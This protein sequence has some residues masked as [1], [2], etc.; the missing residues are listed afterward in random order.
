MV[1]QVFFSQVRTEVAEFLSKTGMMHWELLYLQPVELL[2]AGL[3]SF[4]VVRVT[5]TLRIPDAIENPRRLSGIMELQVQKWSRYIDTLCQALVATKEIESRVKT[6][7]ELEGLMISLE[8]AEQNLQMA[9]IVC[10]KRINAGEPS[11]TDQNSRKQSGIDADPAEK[12]IFS[13][14]DSIKRGTNYFSLSLIVWC[15]LK[16]FCRLFFS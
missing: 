5:A 4:A 16:S 2:H 6:A 15:A 3:S 11:A 9:M 1:C 14:T 8:E 13:I 12:P 7:E 10:Q